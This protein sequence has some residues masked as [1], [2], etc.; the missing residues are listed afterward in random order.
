ML[1]SL[2]FKPRPLFDEPNNRREQPTAGNRKNDKTTPVNS[3]NK[4]E[5]IFPKALF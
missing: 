4:N 1:I 5:T 2:L 3:V